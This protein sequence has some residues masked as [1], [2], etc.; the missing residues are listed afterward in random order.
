MGS[1]TSFQDLISLKLKN[2][3]SIYKG[4]MPGKAINRHGRNTA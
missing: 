1:K 2:L 4:Y 3:G